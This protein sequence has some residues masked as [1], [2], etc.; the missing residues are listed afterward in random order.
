[1]N[2]VIVVLELVGVGGDDVFELDCDVDD[3]LVL[4]EVDGVDEDVED[5]GFVF[6]VVVGCVDGVGVLLFFVLLFEGWV[7]V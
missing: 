2:C 1:M 6:F 7:S 3:E 5:V 4:D